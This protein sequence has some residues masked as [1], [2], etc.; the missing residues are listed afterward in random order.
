[1]I[2]EMDLFLSDE[3]LENKVWIKN[4]VADHQIYVI[5][6]IGKLVT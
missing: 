6:T 4:G 2:A 5:K 1:M 3:D